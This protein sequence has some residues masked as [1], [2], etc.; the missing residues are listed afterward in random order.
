MDEP[1]VSLFEAVPRRVPQF[2]SIGGPV[3]EAPPPVEVV[4]PEPLPGPRLVE[5]E[6]EEPDLE[7]LLA[8]AEARGRQAAALELEAERA[9]VRDTQALLDSLVAQ[10]EV[11]SKAAQEDLSGQ[12]AELV[13][14]LGRRVV[15]DSLALHPRALE[16]VVRAAVGRFP[17]GSKLDV[18]VA[19]RDQERVQAWLPEV[20]VTPDEAL[21]GGCVIQ[22]QTGEVDASLGAVSESLEA[23]VRAWQA[24]GR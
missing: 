13:L 1:F 20:V 3:V 10:I 14:F 17:H 19:P 4:A 18:R 22:A 9:G 2:R 5:P 11:A 16:E 7:T 23:A 21:S 15:G 6:P 8:E 24:E 12:V